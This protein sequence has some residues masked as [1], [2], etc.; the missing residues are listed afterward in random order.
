MTAYSGRHTPIQR[1]QQIARQMSGSNLA[2][3]DQSSQAASTSTQRN[4][5]SLAS[6]PV[7][8]GTTT[9]PNTTYLPRPNQLMLHPGFEQEETPAANTQTSSSSV[10]AASANASSR[11]SPEQVARVALTKNSSTPNLAAILE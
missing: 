1:V 10:Q 7:A 4:S 8:G 3:M 9:V 6:Q 2:A 5:P 11:L